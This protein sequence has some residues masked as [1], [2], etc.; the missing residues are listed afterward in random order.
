MAQDLWAPDYT[1]YVV[2]DAETT[3]KAPAPF[4]FKA[5]PAFIGNKVVAWGWQA[6][7]HKELVTQYG[8]GRGAMLP[9]S[10]KPMLLV[11]HNIKFDLQ[12]MRRWAA[13]D[14]NKHLIWDTGVA[15]YMMTGQRVKMPSLNDVA[16]FYD[17]GAKL[18][19]GV[20]DLWDM[21]VQTEDID[22]KVLTK[23]LEQD[24][25]LTHKVFLAQMERLKD[26]PKLRDHILRV[27]TASIFLAQCELNGIPFDRS[28]VLATAMQAEK[29][30]A[31]AKA[32]LYE[33]A[34][35]RYSIPSTVRD[36]WD[37]TTPSSIGKLLFDL[38]IT[39]EDWEPAG[40]V[41][42]SGKIA[43]RRR[44]IPTEYKAK[45]DNIN[46]TM[47]K[48][49]V[50]KTASGAIQTSDDLLDALSKLRAD[51]VEPVRKYRANL[52][53]YS[54]YLAPTLEW[55]VYG[56]VF[57]SYHLTTTATGR[58]SSAGPNA[59]QFPPELEKHLVPVTPG[60]YM[61]KADF[62][63][64]QI[65][66]V[67]MLSKDSQLIDDLNAGR[68]VHYETGK[69][70]F[71]WKDPSEMNKEDRRVVKNTNFGLI[72]G[73]KAAGLA[74]QTGVAKHL[75]QACIDAFYARYPTVK[76]WV[77][78]NQE[79]V[80]AIAAPAEGEFIN[81]VQVREAF[82]QT[83]AGRILRFTER[84][85]PDWVRRRTGKQLAFSPN[86]IANYPVQAYSDGDIALTYL[87]ILGMVPNAPFT[88]INFV[89]DSVWVQTTDVDATKKVLLEALDELNTK[90]GL[91]VPLKLDFIV[92]DIN[93]K[94][95]G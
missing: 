2:I 54:T 94:Q 49:P 41:L 6:H 7:V 67:A 77:E 52:K 10:N 25:A 45:R 76:T 65:C 56:S 95:I 31:D 5:H 92:E 53:L 13:P 18:D 14:Q 39:V 37:P 4:K 33:V 58:S 78:A 64:L 24:V 47:S 16:A 55:G 27:S 73:G 68:D 83:P 91:S 74:R 32:A 12:Y 93:G 50:P 61:V 36:M 60:H 62:K 84:E 29:D 22:P 15:H 71:G 43:K 90:M 23:Y 42:K 3:I 34:E 75:V 8:G 82:M 72:F 59:Q 81:G 51:I 48:L 20:K 26:L 69:T 44:R 66:G 28:G 30:I 57:P 21:G 1:N 38:P 35:A 17:L 88:P 19:N 79:M 80:E 46:D 89:H 40:R 11:G 70:V 63:Q 86:E 85:A 9:K 87:A